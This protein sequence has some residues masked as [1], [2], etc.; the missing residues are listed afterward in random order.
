[1]SELKIAKIDV[2][3]AELPYSGGVYRLSG[4]REYRSFDG[5]F[6]RITTNTGIEGWGESTPFGSTYIAAH[7]LGVRA[8]IAEIAPW[9]IGLDP[10]RLDRINEAMDAALVGHEHAK[11]PIDIACWDIFEMRKQEQA[12]AH[13]SE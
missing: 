11:T 13:P 10:R 7:A 8:G 9:L 1:M 6:V 12:P 5:T 3:Q 2:F 4:G